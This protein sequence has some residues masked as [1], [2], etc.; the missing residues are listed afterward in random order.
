MINKGELPPALLL[1]HERGF[2]LNAFAERLAKAVLCRG[3]SDDKPCGQCQMCRAFEARNH[4]DFL[5]IRPEKEGD[6]I[7]IARIREMID[8]LMITSHYGGKVALIL[9]AERLNDAAANAM[10][11]T[12]EEPAQSVTIILACHFPSLL[13]PTIRS[14]CRMAHFDAPSEAELVT[15]LRDESGKD[16]AECRERLAQADGRPLDALTALRKGG[17]ADKD[18]ASFLKALDDCIAGR[19][20]ALQLSKE[21]EGV[22]VARVQAW[23]LNR[24]DGEIREHFAG[25]SRVPLGRLYDLYDR[26]VNRCRPGAAKLTPRLLLDGALYEILHVFHAAR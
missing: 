1:H 3:E 18:R 23:L 12:L 25:R 17:G 2:G 8:Y 26:Q 13:P 9:D 4:P 20:P 16:E 15:W 7:K 14:R 10:L 11:K 6:W 5:L 21:W 24:I 19:L 22:P